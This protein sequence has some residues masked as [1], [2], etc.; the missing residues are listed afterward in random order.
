MREQHGILERVLFY[1]RGEA[2]PGD[3]R[4]ILNTLSHTANTLN[5][6]WEMPE[7]PPNYNKESS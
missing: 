3:D 1:V 4:Q 5:R 7:A 2:L 6:L